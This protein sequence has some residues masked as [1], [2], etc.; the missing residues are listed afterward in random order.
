MNGLTTLSDST[1]VTFVETDFSQEDLALFTGEPD[2]LTADNDD[3]DLDTAPVN[4]TEAL[5]GIAPGST[6]V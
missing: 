2:Q 6:I 4:T 3:E 5:P 1:Q